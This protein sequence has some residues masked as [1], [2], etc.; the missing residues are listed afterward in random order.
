SFRFFFSSRRRHTRSKRDWSSDVCSPD[1]MR[2]PARMT[3]AGKSLQR[4]SLKPRFEILQLALGAPSLQDTAF[5]RGD[6]G[7][8]I[9]AIF[10]PQIGRASC[11]ERVECWV[12]GGA[13]R[14][15]RGRGR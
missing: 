14:G 10:E 12:G 7:R 1:L 11:R 2:R 8:V 15:E 9:T 5:E 13:G 6:A 3:D 4:L